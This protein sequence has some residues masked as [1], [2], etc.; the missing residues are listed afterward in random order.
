MQTYISYNFVGFLTW[1]NIFK[2]DRRMKKKKEK[3]KNRKEEKSSDTGNLWAQVSSIIQT[4]L[5][6]TWHQSFRPGI[7]TFLNTL[8]R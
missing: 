1:A 5:H 2:N 6:N 7:W 4:K 8:T 3:N